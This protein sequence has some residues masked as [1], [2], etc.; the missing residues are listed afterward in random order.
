MCQLK[1]SHVFLDNPATT[2]EETFAF[3]ADRAVEL[4]IA[5]DATAVLNAFRKREKE[6][7]TG[8]V[9]GFAIPHAKSSAIKAPAVIVVKYAGCVAEWD[10]MDGEPISVAIS[11]LIPDSEVGTT[12]IKLLSKT[13][14]MLTDADFRD[15]LK[16]SDDACAIAERINA[17]L[18]KKE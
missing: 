12:H 18:R 9:N 10:S 6:G 14:V 16:C 7:S 15:F 13:A 2:V 8:M 17:N 3:L 5:D 4:G 1:A 11:L